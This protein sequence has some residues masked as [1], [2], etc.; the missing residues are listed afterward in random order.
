MS[1]L[2]AVSLAGC[3]PPACMRSRDSLGNYSMQMNGLKPNPVKS[4]QLLLILYPPCI[5]SFIW[6]SSY[7]P[8]ITVV[9]QGQPQMQRAS[10]ISKNQTPLHRQANGGKLKSPTLTYKIQRATSPNCPLST[11]Q[12]H[13]HES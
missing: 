4:L 9:P 12:V 2:A 6:I 1:V 13:S 10:K 5:L 11:H 7:M 3:L 8:G